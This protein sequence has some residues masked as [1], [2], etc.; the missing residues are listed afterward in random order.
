MLLSTEFPPPARDRVNFRQAITFAAQ[1]RPPR[2]G[3]LVLDAAA[4]HWLRSLS[5][6]RRPYRLATLFPRVTNRL[7]LCAGD[8]ELF[9]QALDDLLTDR[10]GGRRGFPAQVVRELKRLR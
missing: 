9:Q 6:G 7:A 8:D 10:R 5:P 1:R 3:D 4:E 2:S